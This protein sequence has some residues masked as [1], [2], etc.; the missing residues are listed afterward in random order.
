[1]FASMYDKLNLIM[2]MISMSGLRPEGVS[3]NESL[4]VVHPAIPADF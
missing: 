3:L 4:P 1:M 2:H